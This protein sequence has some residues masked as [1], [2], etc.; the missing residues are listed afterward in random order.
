MPL[1]NQREVSAGDDILPFHFT[2]RCATSS[3]CWPGTFGLVVLLAL[4]GTF[5]SC[6]DLR[7]PNWR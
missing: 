4:H 7:R 6:Q 2:H 5:G 3:N 1:L